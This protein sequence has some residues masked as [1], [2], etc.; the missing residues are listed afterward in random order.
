M[1]RALV[2]FRNDLRLHD[3]VPLQRSL[4]E[5]D[6]VVPVFVFDPKLVAPDR[7]RDRMRMGPH[8]GRFWL[9]SVQAL[10]KS[11]RDLGSEL[12]VRTG[13]PVEW[14][15]KLAAAFGAERVHFHEE[16]CSDE[17]DQEKAVCARLEAEG[18]SGK[19][20]F[21]APLLH[22]EDLP[23]PIHE[24]PDV[25]T[26]FRREVEKAWIVREPKPT[27]SRIPCPPVAEPGE[28][29]RPEELGFS[30][31]ALDPRRVVEL[32]G[33]EAEG[34]KRLRD[35]VFGSEALGHYKETR[36]GLLEV[37][38]SSKLSPW[39]SLGCLSPRQVYAEVQRF[40]Q[41]RYANESTYWLVF[42]LLWRDYFKFLSLREGT[43]LFKASGVG[44]RKL[45][46]K[47]EPRLFEAWTK[48]E[49]GYPF[50]DAFM[51]ELVATGFMS[52]RGRQNVASF[53]AKSLGIDWRLGAAWFEAHLVDYDPAS[54]WGNW[55]YAA[56]VGTDPRDR[57]FNVV[58]QGRDYDPEGAF[59]KRWLPEL[60]PL[61]P[62]QVHEPWEHGGP[63][64]LVPPQTAFTLSKRKKPKKGRRC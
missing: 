48:G 35:F 57:V 12:V 46:W 54:N 30:E 10:R 49:T 59:M 36:N 26:Q 27:P 24:L 19:G 4:R 42:E 45:P 3:H 23:F 43:R 39:L 17:I 2:W 50:V 16:I 7:C 62:R 28:L 8:R 9:E 53:L 5:A 41:T 47:R 60:A 44:R 11:L 15:P 32:R 52:N 51:K 29:P 34:L 25:F 6:E 20:A 33:G 31:L 58:K 63:R 21:G 18:R 1:N 22:R 14:V 64:L 61:D 38:D 40:E 13:D 56:G 55:Q 37:D